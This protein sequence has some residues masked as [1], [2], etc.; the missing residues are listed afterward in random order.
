M[1]KIIINI[2]AVLLVFSVGCDKNEHILDTKTQ[3]SPGIS[4][5]PGAITELDDNVDIGISIAGSGISEVT[6]IRSSNGD[7]VATAGISDGE[8]TATVAKGD[9]GL[10]SAGD[11]ATLLVRGNNDLQSTRKTSVSMSH[12]V[13]AWLGFGNEAGTVFNNDTEHKFYYEIETVSATVQSVSIQQKIGANGTYA[14]VSGTF[15]TAVDSVV[16]MGS[17]YSNNDTVY[18]K[19][20]ATDGQETTTPKTVS[21]VVNKYAFMNMGE[22]KLDTTTNLAFDL[23]ANEKVMAGPDADT[24]DI[25]M[26]NVQLTSI[27][28]ESNHNA[29]FVPTTKE[30]YDNNDIHEVMAEYDS[31]APVASVPDVEA[32]DYFIYKTTR[33]GSEYYGLIRIVEAYLTPSGEGDY[34]MF[35]YKN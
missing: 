4:L 32:G 3:E 16:F 33:D 20:T 23:V 10:N 27:G 30:V 15:D 29:M 34:L 21:F 2:F 8:G 9:I 35:E 18:M 22:V 1:K 24:A 6:V 19:I 31:G 7:Q 5:S 26:V 25:E 17:N 11:G 28:F 12:P 13:E 14:D